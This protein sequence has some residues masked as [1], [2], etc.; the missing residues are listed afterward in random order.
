MIG[1]MFHIDEGKQEIEF[2][3]TIFPS[4][5][6]TP[7]RYAFMWR[8]SHIAHIYLGKTITFHDTPYIKIIVHNNCG[9]C[10]IY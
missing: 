8:Y 7:E 3:V 9:N 6:Q 2:K 10:N 5:V 1:D 4:P